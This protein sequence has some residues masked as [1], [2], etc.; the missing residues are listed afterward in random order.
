M[1]AGRL[2]STLSIY[3]IRISIIDFL[4]CSNELITKYQLDF[5]LI[6]N[7]NERNFAGKKVRKIVFFLVD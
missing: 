1:R 5:F 4:F 6:K 2:D 7:P 3:T